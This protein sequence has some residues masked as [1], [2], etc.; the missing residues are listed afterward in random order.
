[1]IV[2]GGAAMLVTMAT[3]LLDARSGG[4]A[5]SAAEALAAAGFALGLVTI[6]VSTATRKGQIGRAHV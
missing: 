6:A 3:H 1:M 2:A 5:K 4:H